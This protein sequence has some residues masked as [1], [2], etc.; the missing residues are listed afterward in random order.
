MMHE[1][2]NNLKP[3]KIKCG[4]LPF[5][6]QN[7]SHMEC[8]HLGVF[9]MLLGQEW[10]GHCHV[11]VCSSVRVQELAHIKNNGTKY[12]VIKCLPY[13]RLRRSLNVTLPPTNTQFYSTSLSCLCFLH[14]TY[15]FSHI[16][17][18]FNYL[19]TIYVHTLEYKFHEVGTF[20]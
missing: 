2:K 13:S 9:R 14:N 3:A 5:S 18:L 15:H 8:P 19:S 10:V 20:F 7:P 1:V 16:M 4:F 17:Y 11:G 12:M 6:F